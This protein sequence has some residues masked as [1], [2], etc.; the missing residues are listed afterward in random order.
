MNFYLYNKQ[1]II[2]AKI[3]NGHGTSSYTDVFISTLSSLPKNV[4]FY[5]GVSV[6][7]RGKQ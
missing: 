1:I 7:Q 2:Y 5:F 6:E 4:A 3:I